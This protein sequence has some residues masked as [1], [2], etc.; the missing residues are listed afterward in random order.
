MVCFEEKSIEK[1]IVFNHFL[2]M[3]CIYGRF[4]NFAPIVVNLILEKNVV[5]NVVY[6]AISTLRSIL[7]ITMNIRLCRQ[8]DLPVNLAWSVQSVSDSLCENT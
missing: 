1:S 5:E 2:R 7:C 4:A 8:A 6:T 3:C